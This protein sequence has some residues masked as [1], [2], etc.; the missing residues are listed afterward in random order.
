MKMSKL[1]TFIGGFYIFGGIIVLL[2]L[3][4][5]GSPLNTVFDLSDTYDKIVKLFIAL[6]YIPLGF[7]YI[8]RVSFS[9]WLVLLL[10]IIFFCISADLT[11]KYREQPYIG[12]MVYS[13]F[14]ILITIWKRNEFKKKLKIFR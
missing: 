1:V 5:G 7:L 14:V 13:L 12:N 11:S 4:F 2:S 8:N 6:I 10:A 9:K 3:I